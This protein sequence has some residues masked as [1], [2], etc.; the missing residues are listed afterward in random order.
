MLVLELEKNLWNDRQWIKGGSLAFE[1]GQES[2]WKVVHDISHSTKYILFLGMWEL[3]FLY[4]N[5]YVA[6][7]VMKVVIV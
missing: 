7:G 5:N 1:A 6:I 3:S 4:K 2:W